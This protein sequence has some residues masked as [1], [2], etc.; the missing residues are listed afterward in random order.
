MHRG[1]GPFDYEDFEDGGMSILNP[2]TRIPFALWKR[3]PGFETQQAAKPIY[4][5][6]DPDQS[7]LRFW[8]TDD[9][10]GHVHEVAGK[11]TFIGRC[12][13]CDDVV[14]VIRAVSGPEFRGKGNPG[15]RGRWPRYCTSCQDDRRSERRAESRESMRRLRANPANR[16]VEF[17]RRKQFRLDD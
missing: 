6:R 5:S 14:L 15:R 13:R 3:L 16:R 4:P 17:E 7:V 9:K 12:D 10:R 8:E 1:Q 2:S 11:R